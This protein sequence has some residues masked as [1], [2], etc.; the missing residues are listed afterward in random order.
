MN[1]L[2]TQ[3]RA[4]AIAQSSQRASLLDIRRDPMSFPRIKDYA[5]EALLMELQSSI[6]MVYQYRGQKPNSADEIKVM[7]RSLMA[8]LLADDFGNDTRELS[9]EE[10]RRALRKVGLRQGSDMFGIN[11][12]SLYN[13]I[14]EFR[15]TEVEDA[16]Q[17]IAAERRNSNKVGCSHDAI[18]DKYAAMMRQAAKER[19]DDTIG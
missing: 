10:I 5:P 19:G 11:V 15:N 18:I 2:V 12:G 16:R 1:E 9:M 7:A 13:A 6:L 17:R 8:E 14:Q 4:V 3:Q